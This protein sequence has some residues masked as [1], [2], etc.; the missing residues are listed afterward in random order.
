M[1]QVFPVVQGK[2][3]VL[4][5]YELIIMADWLRDPF[6]WFYHSPWQVILAYQ[7]QSVGAEEYADSISTEDYTRLQR[8]YVWIE[9]SEAKM[10]EMNTHTGEIFL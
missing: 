3:K 1:L 10:A 8:V 6:S 5:Q 4:G 9:K 7:A 2:S